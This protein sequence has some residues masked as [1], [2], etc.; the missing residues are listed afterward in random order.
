M[1]RVTH[2]TRRGSCLGACMCRQLQPERSWALTCARRIPAPQCSRA[3]GL[4][5]HRCRCGQMRVRMR[6]RMRA[7]AGADA[8]PDAG[9]CGCGCG[10][11][12]STTSAQL[13]SRTRAFCGERMGW[14]VLCPW[15]LTGRRTAELACVSVLLSC[16]YHPPSHALQHEAIAAFPPRPHFGGWVGG[17]EGHPC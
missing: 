10:T 13:K 2:V 14:R 12:C 9:R 17:R 11:G 15:E 5:L 7:D 4:V 8:G 6:D 16:V 3:A 1:L